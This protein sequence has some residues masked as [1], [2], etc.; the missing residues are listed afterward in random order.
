[1]LS[2][3]QPSLI[4][5]MKVDRVFNELKEAS[6]RNTSLQLLHWKYDSVLLMS[7]SSALSHYCINPQLKR[8][9]KYR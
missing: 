2:S 7:L 9:C 6:T 3:G 8:E 4:S 5:M 1:M